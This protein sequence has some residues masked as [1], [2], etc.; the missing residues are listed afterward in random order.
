MNRLAGMEKFSHLEDKIYLTIQ[1]VQRLRQERDE[2]ANQLDALRQENAS[3]AATSG[4]LRATVERLKREHDAIQ[5]QVEDILETIS[6]LD[7][8]ATGQPM[9]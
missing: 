4:E 2:F 8:S 5:L 7:P 1:F 3:L 6:V 9:V